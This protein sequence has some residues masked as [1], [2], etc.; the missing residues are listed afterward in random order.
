M[1][2]RQRQNSLF[3][4]ILYIYQIENLIELR[5]YP[6]PEYSNVQ[7]I[8]NTEKMHYHNLDKV[9][10]CLTVNHKFIIR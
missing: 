7:I 1:S 5:D 3:S 2:Q 6:E 4:I 10:S 9:F 8:R